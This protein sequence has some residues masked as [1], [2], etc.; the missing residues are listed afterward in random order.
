[1][2]IIGVDS[3]RHRSAQTRPRSKRDFRRFGLSISALFIAITVAAIWLLIR[4]IEANGSGYLETPSP[5]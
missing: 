4:R 3:R 2:T 1:M 5:K